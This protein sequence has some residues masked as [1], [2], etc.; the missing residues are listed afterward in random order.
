MP[1]AIQDVAL[2]VDGNVSAEEVRRA[3]MAGAGEYIEQIELFDRY[4]KISEGRV[5]LAFTM[6][7][8]APD[9][10]LTAEEVNQ[11]RQDAVGLARERTG[12]ELRS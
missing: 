7:F 6:T 12:A 1:P 8:R 4:D 3:L 5:S 10:T 11:F 9:R 2:V